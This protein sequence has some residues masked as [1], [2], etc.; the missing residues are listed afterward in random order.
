MPTVTSRSLNSHLKLSLLIHLNAFYT[1]QVYISSQ[2]IYSVMTLFLSL[3]HPPAHR[4]LYSP[5]HI[6]SIPPVFWA[7]LS[8]C[9]LRN[10]L[11]SG[12]A[13]E[14]HTPRLS[15]SPTLLYSCPSLPGAKKKC[16]LWWLILDLNSIEQGVPRL[17]IV[18][19]CFCECVSGWDQ[20]LN[21][22]TQ[23][24][25]LSSAMWM[26]IIQSILG[27]NRKKKAKE[28]GIHLFLVSLLSWDISH[29]LLLPSGWDLHHQLPWLSSSWSDQNYITGFP[30]SPACRE[31]I[32]GLLNLCN[33]GNRSPIF[34]LLL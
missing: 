27:L 34:N 1:L 17:N 8:T 18:S 32:M 19:G 3:G 9:F 15:K 24:S 2:L 31:Q 33:C 13:W 25:G 20:H 14:C 10:Q 7:T 29:H 28:K 16:F 23:W 21:W 11:H 6:L 12:A 4:H 30:G 26:G 5:F 22:W